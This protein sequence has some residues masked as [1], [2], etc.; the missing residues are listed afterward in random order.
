MP[1]DTIE[2]LEV[3]FRT[4]EA[5]SRKHNK[6]KSCIFKSLSHFQNSDMKFFLISQW[7]DDGN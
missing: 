6:T 1:N 4:E 2:V 3:W 7:I 5:H